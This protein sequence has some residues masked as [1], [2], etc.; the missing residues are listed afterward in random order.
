MNGAL[1]VAYRQ[2]LAAVVWSCKM[3]AKPKDEDDETTVHQPDVAQMMTKDDVVEAI[4]SDIIFGRMRPRERLLENEL[5]ARFNVGRYVIRGA[6]TELDRLG[7]IEL[8]QNRGAMVRDRPTREVEELYEMRD[9]L[10]HEAARRINFPVSEAFIA[11]LE[12]INEE[13]RV[14]LD[15]GDLDRVAE[16]NN[17]FHRTLFGACGNRF[18]AETI[19]H[20]WQQTA[21]IH[22]Y[23]IGSPEMA[24]RSYAEHIRMIEALRAG[25]RERLQELCV[26][27]M[28]PA[29]NAYKAAHGGWMSRGA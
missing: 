6:L 14:H 11:E 7:L 29:L 28:M 15:T 8:R 20:Y 9:L 10:Q 4:R 1:P 17:A 22:S 13:Y 19:E 23:A 5:A 12:R 2:P 21:A 3:R 24:R 16:A 27:H 25:D 18:L 26:Q